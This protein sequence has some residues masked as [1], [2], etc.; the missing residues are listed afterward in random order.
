MYGIRQGTI[1]SGPGWQLYRQ[2][3][4][5]TRVIM[6]TFDTRKEAEELLNQLNAEGEK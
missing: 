3:D 1:Y 6:A 5:R 2:V 4:D